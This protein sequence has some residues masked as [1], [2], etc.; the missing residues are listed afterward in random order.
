VTRISVLTWNLLA[1][2][3]VRPARM[4]GVRAEDLA[5]D[6]RAPR[7]L[8]GLRALEADVM[9][10]QEVDRSLIPSLRAS[11]QRHEWFVIPHQ[12]EGLA[13]GVRDGIRARAEVQVGAKRV[14][15]CD[16]QLGVRV[17][18]VHLTWSGAPERGARRRGVQ[19]LS[20]ALAWAPDLVAGDFNALPGWPEDEL[21]RQHGY[22][23]VAPPGPT[24]NANR[25]LQDLDRVYLRQGRCVGAT[26]RAELRP[27]SP[28]PSVDCPSDHLP[29]RVDV[30]LDVAERR[31]PLV[32]TVLF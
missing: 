12:G 8:S 2:V 26:Q 9:A 22:Q 21:M 24:C 29:V 4:P 28:M 17:A 6:R 15:A 14:I 19:Q 10:L 31:S 7:L 25:W 13:L 16:T 5:W 3:H 20:A 27:G 23:S 11:F 32:G 18:C 1:P 30:E